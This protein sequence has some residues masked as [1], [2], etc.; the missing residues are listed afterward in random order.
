M[1]PRAAALLALALAAPAAADKQIVFTTPAGDVA[2]GAYARQAGA[3]VSIAIEG[4]HCFGEGAMM[5]LSLEGGVQ[6]LLIS[7]TPYNCG[8][9]VWMARVGPAEVQVL[10]FA[11]I[12]SFLV[13]ADTGDVA[14]DVPP[15][16]ARQFRDAVG[17][18]QPEGQ[19]ARL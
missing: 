14:V 12:E 16:Q 5:E 2:L 18:P 4:R 11:R 13:Y 6:M 7:T 1:G 10:R 3:A 19:G 9:G 17:R 15:V 8:T